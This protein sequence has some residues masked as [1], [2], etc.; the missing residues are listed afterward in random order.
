MYEKELNLLKNSGRFRKR[1]IFD[2]NFVD[3]AS[4]DYLGIAE[5]S[6][7]F[8][9][10]VQH[11]REYKS[12]SSKASSLVTGY[13]H[14]HKLLEDYLCEKSGFEKGIVVGSGFLANLAIFE[15]LG[16]RGDLIV[17]D[18]E[19]HA[20]GNMGVKLSQAEVRYFKHNDLEDLKSKIVGEFK[21]IFIGVEGIYSMKGDLV[22]KD[23]C[24]FAV[25]NGVL[26]VDEAHSVG[27]VGENLMG[28]VDLYNLP[29]N[30]CIKMGTLGKAIGSYGAYILASDEIISFLENR[31][32]SI[33]Y[34]TALSPMDTLLA[35]YGFD[36][37]EKNLNFFKKEI[38]IRQEFF[39][40]ESLI[41]IKEFQNVTEVMELKDFFIKKGILVGAIRPPTV[42]KPLIRV[43]PRINEEFKRILEWL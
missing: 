2:E 25:E 26:I 30:K 18:E 41:Y 36:F 14:S 9:K 7:V 13:H 31:A 23:I 3:L 5:N 43:I 22:T 8:E 24:E 17:L 27:V 42:K 35:Y 15:A 33:I 20:S 12:H 29:T 16:R 34:T 11:C 6:S 38:K 37:I 28:V 21:R 32:K 39:G 1:V 10:A 4:N 19:F 40:I